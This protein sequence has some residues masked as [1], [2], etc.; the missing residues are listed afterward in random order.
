M[1][2]NKQTSVW[3]RA[4]GKTG[5]TEKMNIR[6]SWLDQE[7]SGNAILDGQ[8]GKVWL[9]TDRPA[10]SHPQEGIED[11]VFH[12]GTSR[13]KPLKRGRTGCLRS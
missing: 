6:S 2:P 3:I 7:W 9:S 11:G 5:G 1:T 8:P 10:W 4:Q 13:L 12:R